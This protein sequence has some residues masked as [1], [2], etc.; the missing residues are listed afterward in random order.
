MNGTIGKA[1]KISV[2]CAVSIWVAV[3][4]LGLDNAITAGIITI[5]SIGDTKMETFRTAGKRSLGFLFSM[6]IAAFCFYKIGFT[7]VGFIVYVLI[8]VLV[9]LLLN[10]PEAITI[11]AVLVS[12]IWLTET[13]TWE[14]LLNEFL[15]FVVGI[16]FGILINL[17]LRRN[18]R[19]FDALAEEVDNEMKEILVQMSHHILTEDKS[20]YDASCFVTLEEKIGKAQLCAMQNYDNTLLKK[21]IY[22]QDYIEMRQKQ[23]IVLEEIYK[24]ITM[25]GML[26]KQVHAVGEFLWQVAE[27]YHREND[28]E[29]LLQKLQSIF[30]DMKVQ[31]LPQTREEFEARAVLY[32]I[33]KQME[34]FLRLKN[35]F[36]KRHRKEKNN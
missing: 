24:S 28:V 36:V 26:P 5:L 9:C 10:W 32:Y 15:L 16:S 34:E 11:N 12:H 2:A 30:E 21:S 6:A 14:L 18:N 29:D 35:E 25:I 31:N 33:L 23:S 7:T 8:F 19:E 1:I 3:T 27:E 4:L 20:E 22:E 17:L 13:M